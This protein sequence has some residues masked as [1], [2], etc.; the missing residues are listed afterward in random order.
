M[1]PRLALS[2]L[3]WFLAL[4]LM[5][6]PSSAR[7]ADDRRVILVTID[8]MRWQ[9]VFGGAQESLLNEKQGVKNL[10]ELKEKFWR[11]TPE[12]RREALMPFLWAA[13]S[14]QGQIFGDSSKQCEAKLTNGLKFSYPGYS[15]MLCGFADP[16]VDSNDKVPNPNV[17]VLEWLNG[18]PGLQGKV[19]A[20]GTWDVL[21]SIVNRGRSKLPGIDGYVP[22]SDEPLSDR[23]KMLNELLPSLS[24]LWRDNNYDFYPAIATMEHLRKHEPRVL[25]FMFGETD[26]WAHSRRYDCYLEAA[27]NNDRFLKELWQTIQSTPA[28]ANK[29]TLL[30]TTDH[31]RGSTS[32]NWTD[33]GE[34]V[35]G[36]ENIWIA[37]IGPDTPAMGLRQKVSVTQSQIAATLAQALG[38]DYPA[39]QPKA[40]KPLPGVIERK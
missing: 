17:T 20:F 15:E 11:D 4:S 13:I 39:A 18:R 1:T 14:K 5:I 24:R 23:Q 27:H 12:A 21:T 28:F 26:E 8:G 7:A 36:A 40:A 22:I 34:K 3:G 9:E 16:R 29:T 25:Y 30:I 33:H 32:D 38:E 2:L 6:T 10:P 35:E 19:A 37:A 31:G